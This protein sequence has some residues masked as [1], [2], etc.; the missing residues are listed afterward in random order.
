MQ[1]AGVAGEVVGPVLTINCI[2]LSEGASIYDVHKIKWTEITLFFL[3]PA[4]LCW[5]YLAGGV[6]RAGVGA[7]LHRG[8]VGRTQGSG[9][10][11]VRLQISIQMR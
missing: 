4:M 1:R 11:G 6:G 8:R 5:D 3:A 10:V 7:V 9:Q 2:K